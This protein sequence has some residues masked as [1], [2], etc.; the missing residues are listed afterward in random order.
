MYVNF[1]HMASLKASQ[2]EA[3][4]IVVAI[5]AKRARGLMVDFAVRNRV[6]L[7][8]ELKAFKEEVYRFQP[9]LSKADLFCFIRLG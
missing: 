8:E 3:K 7:V 9:A 6:E 2:M 4:G 1:K 5:H